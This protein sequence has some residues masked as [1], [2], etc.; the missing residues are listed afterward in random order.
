VQSY[1]RRTIRKI[2]TWNYQ[3]KYQLYLL[4]IAPTM[5]KHKTFLPVFLLVII[6]AMLNIFRNDLINRTQLLI[7]GRIRQKAFLSNAL[8][9]VPGDLGRKNQIYSLKG[10]DRIWPHRVNSI[11]RLRYLYPDFAGFECDIRFDAASR[12]LYVAHDPEDISPLVFSDYLS[13]ADREHKLFW[14]DVKNLDSLN[15]ELFCAAIQQLDQRYDIKNRIIIESADTS[16]LIR[17]NALGWLGSLYLPADL[18]GGL[19]DQNKSMVAITTFLN[20]HPTLISQDIGMHDFITAHFRQVKQLTW[21]IRF[22]DALNQDLLLKL[23]NDTSLLICL[24]NVKSPGY[25]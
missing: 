7:L 11:Q 22:K 17:I 14:L 13:Q 25:R 18:S 16:A 24:I 12:L 23:A 10:L 4:G 3:N 15:L 1:R 2:R 20:N 5:P 19:I 9:T 6:I 8:L 21:D